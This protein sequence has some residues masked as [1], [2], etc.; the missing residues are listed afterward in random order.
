MG[1]NVKVSVQT[2]ISMWNHTWSVWLCKK[3][4]S[5]KNM[6]LCVWFA[7]DGNVHGKDACMGC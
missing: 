4:C 5:L 7:C 1:S 6:T 3:G 2:L